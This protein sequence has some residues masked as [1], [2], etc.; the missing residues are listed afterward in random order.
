[1]KY[2][3]MRR[4]PIESEADEERQQAQISVSKG[5][6]NFRSLFVNMSGG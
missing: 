3:L 5:V 1:M 4:V 6:G 2:R